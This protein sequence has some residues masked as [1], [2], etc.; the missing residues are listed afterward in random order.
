MPIVVDSS[1]ILALALDDED[2]TFAQTAV[3]AIAS[4]GG[5]APALLWYEVRNALVVNERRGRVTADQTHAFLQELDSLPITLEFPPPHDAVM[6]LA[7]RFALTIYDAT[8]L[9][10]SM[11]TAA[12]I[13]SLDDQLRKAAQAAGALLLGQ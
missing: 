8:Y 10:V 9:E 1:V 2:A 11:R 5:I 3:Q 6:E 4:D 13:A 7:R 12:P